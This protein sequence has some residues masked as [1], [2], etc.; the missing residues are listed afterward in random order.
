MCDILEFVKLIECA[1]IR[2]QVVLN[3]Q[4]VQVEE[5]RLVCDI[6]DLVFTQGHSLQNR[7]VAEAHNLIPRFDLVLLQV[8]EF[9]VLEVLLADGVL[10]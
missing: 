8:D 9:Q 4:H 2:Y 6:S 7:E 1:P 5:P 3:G 10:G